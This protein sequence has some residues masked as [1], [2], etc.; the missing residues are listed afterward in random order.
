MRELVA[1][2]FLGL[3]LSLGAAQF[4]LGDGSDPMPACRHKVC[5]PLE[6]NR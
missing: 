5:P 4:A 1:L 3:V 6:M 2:L